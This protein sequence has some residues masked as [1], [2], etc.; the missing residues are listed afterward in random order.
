MISRRYIP[1][2]MVLLLF[3]GCG[4][5]LDGVYKDK[6]AIIGVITLHSDGTW[7][8]EGMGKV[9]EGN[10]IVEKNVLKLDIKNPDSPGT[11]FDATVPNNPAEAIGKQMMQ[12]LYTGTISDDKKSID[13][14]GTT[15][16]KQP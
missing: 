4:H 13:M 1:L 16:I 9:A 12:K 11:L 8:L 6:N 14:M 5:G 7:K 15:F 10:Y 2:F 3:A